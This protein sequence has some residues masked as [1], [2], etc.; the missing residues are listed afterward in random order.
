M[1]PAGL[2]EAHDSPTLTER[3]QPADLDFKVDIVLISA[4]GT[5]KFD[6]FST[7]LHICIC[8]ELNT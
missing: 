3:T 7:A 1:D 8:M 2:A 4:S 5:A 6:S